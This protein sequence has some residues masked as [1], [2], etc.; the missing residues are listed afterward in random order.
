M[1]RRPRG[2]GDTGYI[3]HGGEYLQCR[4]FLNLTGQQEP[5]EGLFTDGSFVMVEGDY[6]EDEILLV[7][8]M[9]HPPSERREVA[10]GIYGHVDFLGKGAT[11]VAEDV[12]DIHLQHGP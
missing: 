1:S 3:W 9:G 7:A 12:S 10:R 8:E 5:S 4:G 11:T 2:E 6:T